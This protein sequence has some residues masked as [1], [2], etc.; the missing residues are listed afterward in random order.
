MGGHQTADHETCPWTP[1]S[2]NLKSEVRVELCYGVGCL[3]VRIDQLQIITQTQSQHQGR[4]DLLSITDATEVA[5]LPC[6]SR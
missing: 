1:C 2:C 5:P 3:G 6:G 4:Q